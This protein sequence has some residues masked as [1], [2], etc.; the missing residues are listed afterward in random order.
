MDASK[1]AVILSAVIAFM[2]SKSS[3]ARVKRVKPS[4]VAKAWR[5]ASI[6]DMRETDISCL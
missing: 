6:L 2:L 3:Q 5:L 1:R 4:G